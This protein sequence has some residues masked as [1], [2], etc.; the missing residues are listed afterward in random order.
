MIVDG[1]LD[2]GYTFD[3]ITLTLTTNDVSMLQLVNPSTS[4]V[5]TLTAAEQITVQVKNYSTG[6][7]T[8]VPVSYQI[9]NG[10]VITEIHFNHQRRPGIGLY[11]YP[12]SQSLGL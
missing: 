3:D 1:N 4:N 2:D 12:N 5:C 9:D 7:L 11:I 6:A 8:N 10:T